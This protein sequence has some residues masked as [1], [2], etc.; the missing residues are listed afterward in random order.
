M[1][2]LTVIFVL[3]LLAAACGGEQI[4]EQLAEQAIGGNADVNISG[5][6]DDFSIS[7]E[8]DEGSFELGSGASLPDG[9]N[10]PVPDGGDVTAS[11]SDD[12]SAGASIMYAGDRYDEIVGF[13]ESWTAGTGDEW[14]TSTSTFELDGETQR[15]SQW[16]TI[17]NQYF[18]LVGDC[19]DIGTGEFTAVCVT[20]NENL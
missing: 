10:V 13:Y 11:F 3:A 20:I 5:D 18:I 16:N 2:R 12:S 17:G 9:L 6:G 1:R 8:S 4:S 14:Q 15:N 19:I 7:V